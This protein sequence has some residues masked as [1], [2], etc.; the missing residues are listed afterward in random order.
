MSEPTVRLVIKRDLARAV[1]PGLRGPIF[2]VSAEGLV[3]PASA[4]THFF[5]DAI[6]AEE[7]IRRSILIHGENV[8]WGFDA[9]DSE[10]LEMMDR[11]RKA[12]EATKH[13]R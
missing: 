7:W 5:L 1:P 8:A 11:A 3:P 10:V 6:R 9:G 4:T 2:D 13:L 12:A